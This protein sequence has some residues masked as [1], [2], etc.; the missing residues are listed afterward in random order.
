MSSIP[1]LYEFPHGFAARLCAA[2]AQGAALQ[3]GWALF[4]AVGTIGT[5]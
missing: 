1:I 4:P 2:G 5:P 3:L